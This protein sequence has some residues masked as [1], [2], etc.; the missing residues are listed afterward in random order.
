MKK[1]ILILGVLLFVSP[2]TV[3]AVEY[4]IDRTNIT[5]QLQD[6]GNVEVSETHTYTFD[7]EFNGITR[8]L[9]PKEET[10]ITDFQASEDG[11]ELEIEREEN[12]YKIHRTGE[13]ETVTVDLTYIIEDGVEVYS[14][15]GEFYWPFFDESNESDYE[16]MTITVMPP[17]PSEAEAAYGF[18]AAYDTAEISSGGEVTFD[19]GEVSEGKN[20]DIRVAYDAALFSQA[21]RTRDETMLPVIQS[22]KQELDEQ[23]AARAERQERWSSMG[24]YIIG[25][26]LLLALLIS[27]TGWRKRQETVREAERQQSGIGQFP[28]TSMSLPAT[29]MFTNHGQVTIPMMT[30]ALLELVRKGYVEKVSEEEFRIVQRNTDY[31]HESLLMEWLF[32][33]VGHDGMFHVE[34]L[35]VYLEDEENIEEYQNSFHSWSEG[36]K[37]E[38]KQYDLYEDNTKPRWIAGIAAL[39][40]V[41]FAILFP[42]FGVYSW[43]VGAIVLFFYFLFFDIAYRPLTFEGQRIKQE[44]EPLKTGDKWQEWEEKEQITAFLYQIGAG[45]RKPDNDLTLTAVTGNDLILFMVLA[46]TLD[47]SFEQADQHAA[48]SATTGAGAGGGAGVGGGGGGSGAF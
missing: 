44:L 18:D 20:G 36:V 41:P 11:A 38:V 42:V 1:I 40:V 3:L 24:P 46:G 6:D 32:D 13:D 43:M 39:A 12:L 15:V 4:E 9:I 25:A 31:E 48:V 22:D 26:F 5:A 14:D 23:M 47:H 10:S 8:E 27:V 45:K 19:M 7:G 34:D 2:W 16:N 37:R 17:E 33:E 30:S 21:E 29:L 28:K 35:E